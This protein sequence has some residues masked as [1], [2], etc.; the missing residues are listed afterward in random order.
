MKNRAAP[1][2]QRAL[3]AIRR[4]MESA[5][6]HKSVPR[7]ESAS[8][9]TRSLRKPN[10]PAKTPEGSSVKIRERNQ[11]ETVNPTR[12]PEGSRSFAKI[13]RKADERLIPITSMNPEKRSSK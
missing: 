7:A 10:Q 9:D 8:P 13:G 3:P 5:S 11:A 2:P 12:T 4:R 1:K 6:E